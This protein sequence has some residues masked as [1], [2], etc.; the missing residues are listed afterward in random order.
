MSATELVPI[1]I[2][3]ALAQAGVTVTEEGGVR[4]VMIPRELERTY[5][6]VQPVSQV[7]AADPDWSP[8][9]V[10]INLDPERHCYLQ[11]GKQS[12]TKE[13]IMLLGHAAGMD[14]STELVPRAQLLPTQIGFKATATMRR[15]D[16]T[17]ARFEEHKIDDYEDERERIAGTRT[18]WPV[19]KQHLAAKTESKAALRAVSLALTLKRGG[20]TKDEIAKPW[21][22]IGWS[23]TP[24]D[25]E[26]RRERVL[27]AGDA[28][29]GRRS[30]PAPT[31]ETPAL[32][33]YEADG[34]RLPS[35]DVVDAVPASAAPVSQEPDPNEPEPVAGEIPTD[36]ASA[37]NV[38]FG[39][40]FRAAGKKV[41]EVRRE[42]LNHVAFEMTFT[43]EQEPTVQACRTWAAWLN[44]QQVQA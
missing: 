6:I 12:L 28:L 25:P 17:L 39:E 11:D 29:A 43:P 3:P 40:G 9:L 4:S 33:E 18:K 8:R 16:G 1:A 31:V 13:A 15:S 42:Y 20:Y 35:P 41:S 26:V 21:L 2:P 14:V 36:V 34:D 30:L 23:L 22:I 38:I 24:S 10:L 27:Q 44:S 37:G 19:A 5:N 32:P 7:A